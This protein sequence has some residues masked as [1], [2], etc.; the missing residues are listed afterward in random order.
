M[1]IAEMRLLLVLVV[2]VVDDAQGIKNKTFC[3]RER[4]KEGVREEV[5]RSRLNFK[6][7]QMSLFDVSLCSRSNSFSSVILPFLLTGLD[8]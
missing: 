3:G 4:R 6:E 2:V 8:R 1:T 5:E 7:N